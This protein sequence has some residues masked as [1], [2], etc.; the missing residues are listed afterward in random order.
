LIRM[1]DPDQA[2][3]A[4]GETRFG[5]GTILGNACWKFGK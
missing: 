1:L 3:A 5:G 4:L 2:F